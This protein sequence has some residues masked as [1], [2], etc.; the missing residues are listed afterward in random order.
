MP[1]L[2]YN[3]LGGA[4]FLDTPAPTKE[5]VLKDAHATGRP[6]KPSKSR[7]VCSV[8]DFVTMAYQHALRWDVGTTD[9][10]IDGRKTAIRVDVDTKS[11][12]VE[13]RLMSVWA[14]HKLLGDAVQVL[15]TWNPKVGADSPYRARVGLYF[16]KPMTD[17]DRAS[18]SDMAESCQ[19]P[20][21]PLKRVDLPD[22]QVR[23]ELMSRVTLSPMGGLDRECHMDYDEFIGLSDTSCIIDY[24]GTGQAVIDGKMADSVGILPDERIAAHPRFIAGLDVMRRVFGNSLSVCWYNK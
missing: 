12:M 9:I 15:W 8:L 19:W 22:D 10:L 16:A 1:T 6:V 20:S 4:V 18:Y 21:V 5:D 11:C 13:D 14:L 24:D 17:G 2:N 3:D 23:N 7:F